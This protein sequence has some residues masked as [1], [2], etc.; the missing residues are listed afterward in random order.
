MTLKPHL[1]ALGGP[2]AS[3]ADAAVHARRPFTPDL[4]QA[5][6]QTV[7]DGHAD[8]AYYVDARAVMDRL[9]VLLPGRWH[10]THEL[11]ERREPADGEERLLVY[12]CHLTV[13]EATYSDVGDGADHKAAQSDALKRAAVH[14]GI[15]HCL[16]RVPAPRMLPGP[17]PHELRRSTRGRFHL[18]AANHGWLREAYRRWLI[19]SGVAEYGLPLDHGA[20]AQALAPELF[21]APF[22]PPRRRATRPNGSTAGNGD[23]AGSGALNGAPSPPHVALVL[24][25]TTT[26]ATTNG[27]GAMPRTAEEAV[28]DGREA[29]PA[30]AIDADLDGRDAR[31]AEGPTAAPGHRD[32]LAAAVRPAADVEEVDAMELVPVAPIREAE[33]PAPPEQRAMVLDAAAQRG[34]RRE[35]VEALARAVG[36]TMLDRLGSRGLR[37]LLA[38]LD[39]AIASE[40]DDAQLTAKLAELAATPDGEPASDRLAA[41]L[42]GREEARAAATP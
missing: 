12:R 4:V 6:I 18:D 22:L 17:G 7:G 33:L 19:A 26:E 13:A 34:F 23:G 8:I 11:V 9:N 37:G 21:P 25:A 35:T 32:G 30:D 14:V 5:K 40:V 39:S 1:P 38:Y 3:L 28:P 27:N 29:T 41:W 42:L 2:C 20:V 16:Y 24:G 31:D 15:G 36:E 10:A